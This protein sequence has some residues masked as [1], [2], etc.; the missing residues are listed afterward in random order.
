[1]TTATHTLPAGFTARAPR[2]DDPPTICAL[3]TSFD[4][5]YNGFVDIY[6]LA[7][8][9]EEW[10]RLDL[11]ADAWVIEGPDGRMAGYGT[12]TDEGSG[13]LQA[14]AYVHPDFW[15]RG[16]G[17]ALVRLM[18]ARAGV[19]IGRAP[20]GARVVVGNGVL[21]NDFAAHAILEAEGYTLVR[22]HWRMAIT[23]DAPPPA[24]V[25]PEG[26]AVRTFERGRDDRA[27]FEAVEEA[28]A[29][30]WGHTPRAF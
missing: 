6:E 2:E 17:T 8:I 1:M 4:I 10:G 24:P 29:D 21:A 18:D 25:W 20:E 26:I 27:V 5:A 13:R 16:V 28:F 23:L 9:R 7:D 15:G 14:D 19:L 11:A 3:M 12:L 22:T 30:H